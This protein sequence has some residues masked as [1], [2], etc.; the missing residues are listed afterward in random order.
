MFNPWCKESL[1]EIFS[2]VLVAFSTVVFEKKAIVISTTN[3][4]KSDVTRDDFGH[5]EL[6]KIGYRVTEGAE[7]FYTKQ[8]C[9]GSALQVFDLSSKPRKA[10]RK[11]PMG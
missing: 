5:N 11:E 3:N 9:C 10:E 6:P 7:N 2:S 1:Y 8:F 4:A